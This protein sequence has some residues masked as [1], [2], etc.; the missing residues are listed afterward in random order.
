MPAIDPQSLIDRYIG[1]W[2]EPDPGARRKTVHD[3][4]AED[5]LHILR[6]PQEMHDKAVGLGFTTAVLEARGHEEL[7]ARVERAYE[8][9]VAPGT[10]LFRVQEAPVLL[11]DVITFRWESYNRQEG[12][13]AGGGREFL[14]LGEDGRIRLDYQFVE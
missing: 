10:Y 9:F 13:A 14:V 6:P 4:W 2:N 1:V 12:R 7:C 8:D 3:L 11:R 5:G